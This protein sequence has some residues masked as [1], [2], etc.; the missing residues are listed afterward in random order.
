MLKTFVLTHHHH[1]EICTTII[2]FLEVTTWT[3]PFKTILNLEDLHST[4]HFAQ[5]GVRFHIWL[6]SWHLSCVS[7]CR[8]QFYETK[9]KL[10]HVIS[11]LLKRWGSFVVKPKI[12]FAQRENQCL[13]CYQTMVHRPLSWAYNVNMCRKGIDRF[14]T[15]Y[16]TQT[17]ILSWWCYYVNI[18]CHR[19]GCILEIPSSD[20]TFELCRSESFF[21]QIAIQI[22]LWLVKSVSI[23]YLCPSILKESELT[24]GHFQTGQF[25]IFRNHSWI[26]LKAEGPTFY[27]VRIPPPP[28]AGAPC[29]FKEIRCLTYWVLS[30]LYLFSARVH[31]Q[32]HICSDTKTYLCKHA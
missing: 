25:Q 2:F 32:T 15:R 28:P 11:P 17:V 29:C 10:S 5:C 13:F 22:L 18:C 30:R 24:T 21:K 8:L 7:I 12:D 3:I 14:M 6:L 31:I 1:A 20:L 23:C 4:A 9:M 27:C 19:N 16:V 26:S